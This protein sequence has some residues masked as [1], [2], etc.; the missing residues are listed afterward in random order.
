[1]IKKKKKKLIIALT[2]AGIIVAGTSIYVVSNQKQQASNLVQDAPQVN[3]VSDLMSSSTSKGESYLTGKVA[4]N[5][6][7][8]LNADSAKGKIN[9]VFVKVGDKVTKGQKLFSYS[10]PDGQIAMEEAETDRTKLQNKI[11]QLNESIATKRTQLTKKTDELTAL[12]NKVNNATTEEKESL[13]QEKKSLEETVELG[14]NE[15]ETAKSELS[16]AKL[17]LQKAERTQQLTNEKYGRSEVVSDVDG[18]IQKIDDTQINSTV[19]TGSQPESF[20][21]IM[22]T[23]VLRVLGKVD[24]FQKGEIAV[25]QPVKLIDRKDQSKTWRGK[26]ARV[27]ATA[28]DEKEESTISK[29]PFEVVM[30]NGEDMPNI[31]NHV[32]IQP[33][34]EENAKVSLPTDYIMNEKD[35]KFVWK[36][37]KGQVV[38]QEVTLGKSNEEAKT[39]EVNSGLT[40]EDTIVFPT[41]LIKEGMKVPIHD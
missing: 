15:I 17:D 19:S 36:V 27:D 9:E 12:T 4:P 38:K 2:V 23:S 18:I 13:N 34:K 1:M 21:E 29:Y 3:K 33:E 22:D 30:E 20:M 32:Y 40:K 37:I 35:K 39:I 25:D 11:N 10:N 6:T 24:E 31:G 14:K 41:K 5:A 16:D 8:K 7:S 26:I 28:T